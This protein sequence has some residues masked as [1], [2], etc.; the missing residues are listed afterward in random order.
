MSARYLGNQF[1]IH[2]GGTDLIFPHHENERAQSEAALGKKP[3]V[4]YWLHT[5]ML[6]VAG[7]KMSKSLR[8]IVPLR[9]LFNEYDPRIIRLW[10]ATTHYRTIL[11]F[12]DVALEQAKRNYERL[13]RVTNTLRQLLKEAEPSFR[14]NDEDIG[15][16][17]ELGNI[18]RGFY[19]AM[20]DDFNASKAFSY[21]Y[22]LTKIFFS[23]ITERPEYTILVKTYLLL[24]E[25]NKVLGVLD[26]YLNEVVEVLPGE[27]I[28]EIL[29]D[30]RN[31]LRSMKMY[32]LSDNIRER[33]QKLGILLMDDKEKTRWV[34]KTV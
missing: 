32:D 16:L 10:L 8:N 13:V 27:E 26:E 22:E 24:E 30:V 11:S 3:W 4:K 2:G 28:L 5:G 12:S 21:V 25:F 20:D 31:A 19:S 33:L 1:D 9:D 29:I 23:K 17:K 15:I 7:K 18:R 6:E 34:M 14:L